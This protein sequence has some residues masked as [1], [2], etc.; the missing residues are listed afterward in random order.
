ML[1]EPKLEQRD[2]QPYVAIAAHVP[3]KDWGDIL[4]PLWG[5]VFGWLGTQGIAPTGA[6][7]IRYVVRTNRAESLRAGSRDPLRQSGSAPTPVVTERVVRDFLQSV[8][9]R[10][11]ALEDA[12]DA[13]ETAAH[14][15]GNILVKNA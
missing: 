3:M 8:I 13:C 11:D 5:E 1:T 4:P 7:F 12:I 2:P 15:V 9:Q 14:R 10:A 6:P